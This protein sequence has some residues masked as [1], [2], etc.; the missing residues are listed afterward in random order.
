M[1]RK[2]RV[3][4]YCFVGTEIQCLRLWK[5]PS[6]QTSQLFWCEQGGPARTH[7][8]PKNNHE[9]MSLQK[10]ESG[11][12]EQTQRRRKEIWMRKREREKNWLMFQKTAQIRI[13]QAGRRDN[14]L[15]TLLCLFYVITFPHSRPN[16]AGSSVHSAQASPAWERRGKGTRGITDCYCRCVSAEGDPVLG[17]LFGLSGVRGL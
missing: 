9:R 3:S 10:C 16:A 8:S 1:L 4:S 6:W 2:Y 17:K 5:L 11:M 13:P 14:H 15:L 7:V 12:T